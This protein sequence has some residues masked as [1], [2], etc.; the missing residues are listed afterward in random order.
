MTGS[1]LEMDSRN[2]PYASDGVAGVTTV[3]P[4]VCAK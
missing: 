4:A 1:S 3:S 2:S